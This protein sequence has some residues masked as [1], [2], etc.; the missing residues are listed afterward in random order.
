MPT[1]SKG[2][3]VLILFP[4]PSGTGGKVRPGLVLVDSGDQ[5][6]LVAR[7]T[8]TKFSTLHDLPIVDWQA[9][10]LSGPQQSDFTRSVPSRKVM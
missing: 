3:I 9:A 4:F 2:E 1:Y 7:I 5:D 6:V 10:G 8:S